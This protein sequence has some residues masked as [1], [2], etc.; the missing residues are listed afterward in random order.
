MRGYSRTSSRAQKYNLNRHHGLFTRT[1]PPGASG[2]EIGPRKTCQDM[3]IVK[4]DHL[5]KYPFQI[6]PRIRS[7]RRVNSATGFHRTVILTSSLLTTVWGLRSWSKSLGGPCSL[8]SAR[9]GAGAYL[10]THATRAPEGRAEQSKAVQP[11]KGPE[12]DNAGLGSVRYLQVGTDLHWMLSYVDEPDETLRTKVP[13]VLCLERQEF[14]QNAPSPTLK[15]C[16][17]VKNHL[18]LATTGTLHSQLLL[19]KTSRAHLPSS[20]L[21]SPSFVP[22]PSLSPS[23]ISQ[24]RSTRETLLD[25]PYLRSFHTLSLP[26]PITSSNTP[27]PIGNHLQPWRPK[28]RRSVS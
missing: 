1:S 12:L 21:E 15:C 6:Y 7:G 11:K 25:P 10:G 8:L 20:L 2:R 18:R 22:N 26:F 24:V 4:K 14:P 19:P 13:T 17:G 23:Y 5:K 9:R 28:R 16:G 27:I 3:Q